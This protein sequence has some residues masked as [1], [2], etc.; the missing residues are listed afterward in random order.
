[1][2]RPLADDLLPTIEAIA[3]YTLGAV[4]EA[5]VR[6]VRHLIRSHG[7]P[8]KKVGGL[9]QSRKS[10]IDEYYAEPDQPGHAA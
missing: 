7:L 4:T 10:W 1:M 6:R 9:I 8:S 3:A 2:D 5:S